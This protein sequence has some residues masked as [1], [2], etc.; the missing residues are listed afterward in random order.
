MIQGIE[1]RKRCAQCHRARSMPE[2]FLCAR[3]NRT[4]N[5]KRLKKEKNRK[6][7]PVRVTPPS[8]EHNCAP[9]TANRY[10]LATSTVV[11]P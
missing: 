5:K 4:K 1:V 10:L 6:E 3:E 8:V 7:K 11:L 2:K 9:A